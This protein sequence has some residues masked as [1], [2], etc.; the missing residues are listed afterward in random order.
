M[1]VSEYQSTMRWLFSPTHSAD[2]ALIVGA[3][4]QIV[5]Q[6]PAVTPD[7]KEYSVTFVEASHVL[8]DRASPFD[9]NIQAEAY[10]I[11]TLLVEECSRL[12]L[13][14]NVRFVEAGGSS[15]SMDAHGC[16]MPYPEIIT[17]QSGILDLLPVTGQQAG[18][19][20]ACLG[21]PP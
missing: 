14:G 9:A 8:R 13:Q 7:I 6:W 12:H 15:R 17:D 4:S 21:M 11:G 18:I 2:I 16:W 3:Y 10:A 5:Q 1:H 20:V 19:Y